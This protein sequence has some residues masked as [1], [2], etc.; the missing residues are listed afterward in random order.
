[1]TCHE[2]FLSMSPNTPSQFFFLSVCVLT[3]FI[4]IAQ[5]GCDPPAL[6][7][8]SWN[9]KPVPFHP[10]TTHLGAGYLKAPVG[11]SQSQAACINALSH[12]FN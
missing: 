3:R 7:F 6:A 8:Q 11:G 12:F 5:T 9:Y 4:C 1:M 2:G 10:P